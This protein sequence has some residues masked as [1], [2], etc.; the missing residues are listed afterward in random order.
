MN[1]RRLNGS[2]GTTRKGA[3]APKRRAGLPTKAQQAARAK[4]LAEAGVQGN[5]RGD[6]GD[7]ARAAT[8]MSLSGITADTGFLVGAER[9]KQRALL[10]LKV[11]I[12]RKLR[13]SVPVAVADD[14]LRYP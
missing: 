10:P 3:K 2:N 7:R 12:A 11:A 8:R 6:R 9:S 1:S 14:H 5:T 13:I 4:I